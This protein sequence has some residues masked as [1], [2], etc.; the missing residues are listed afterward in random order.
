MV[1]RAALGSSCPRSLL[2]SPGPIGPARAV[3]AACR[4]PGWGV[5]EVGR[6]GRSRAEVLMARVMMAR[7]GNAAFWWPS[8]DPS[9]RHPRGAPRP[10][11][12]STLLRSLTSSTPRL[13]TFTGWHDQQNRGCRTQSTEAKNPHRIS[14]SPPAQPPPLDRAVGPRGRGVRQWGSASAGRVHKERGG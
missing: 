1:A 9:T 13:T 11:S 12:A 7:G 10:T 8:R 5:Q 2:S 6:R 14:S 4:H 3:R